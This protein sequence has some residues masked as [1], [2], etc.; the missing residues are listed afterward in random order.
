MLRKL[1]ETAVP[2]ET[3]M[4]R[5]K[6]KAPCQRKS[7]EGE[8]RG[9]RFRGVSKNGRCWQVF[10][11]IDKKKQY[12]GPVDSEGEAARLYDLLTVVNHGPKVLVGINLNSKGPDEFR[13]HEAGVN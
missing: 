9:S 13:L 2:S 5:G 4:V 6:N 3:L 7:L 10:I 1:L 12:V 8:F 11:M